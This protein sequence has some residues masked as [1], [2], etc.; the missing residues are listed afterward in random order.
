MASEADR[1][2]LPILLV[3]LAWSAGHE[4]QPL[5]VPARQP[6]AA[7]APLQRP[8]LSGVLEGT[9]SDPLGEPV[10][11]FVLTAYAEALLPALLPEGIVPAGPSNPLGQQPG[12]VVSSLTDAQGRFRLEG[13]VP[14]RFCVQIMRWQG[15][16]RGAQLET[17]LYAT[18][19]GPVRLVLPLHRL[20]LDVPAGAEAFCYQ[21]EPFA[22][23]DFDCG[24]LLE[25]SQ[26][27]ESRAPQGRFTLRAKATYAVGLWSKERGLVEERCIAGAGGTYLQRPG[28]T[29]PGEVELG[30]IDL[31][32]CCQRSTVPVQA[33]VLAPLTRHVL[34]DERVGSGSPGEFNKRLR[35]P[36][37][38]YRVRASEIEPFGFEP[39]PWSRFE[40]VE[41]EE[42]VRVESGKTTPLQLSLTGGGRLGLCVEA[43]GA[44]FVL[45][46]GGGPEDPTWRLLEFEPTLQG[47]S[48]GR[49]SAIRSACPTR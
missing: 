15:S 40:L 5:P 2:M 18:G 31:T 23:S 27:F 37:G 36:P 39:Q 47:P 7:Q 16:E 25:R 20:E 17:S 12:R 32:V 9:L 49:L 45:A 8:D 21:L 4:E 6:P 43:P 48:A 44:E 19:E 34:V 10:R 29:L 26:M 13:L 11:G 28:L 24:P 1:A 33:R 22:R 42:E 14:G 41:A 46:R 3:A 30:T 35:L 38:R